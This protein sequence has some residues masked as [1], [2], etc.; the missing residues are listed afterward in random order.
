MAA[1]WLDELEAR[2]EQR[3][4]S[5]LRANPAQEALLAEQAA[6]DRQEWL[7]G[8]RLELQ[9]QAERQ[10]QALL[11]LAEEIRAW[12]QRVERARAARE[13]V[14]AGRAEAH[15]ATLMEQGRQRWQALEQLGE[16]FTAVERELATGTPPPARGPGPAAPA[17]GSP[18]AAQGAAADGLDAAWSQFEAQ[19]DLQE[20]QRRLQR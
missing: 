2:L 8:Q 20:L 15:I 10:R 1:S 19:Q 6:R 7:R 12:Q 17:S 18:T 4:E 5:F 11:A 16:R 13:E 14:L 3:L 9:Q